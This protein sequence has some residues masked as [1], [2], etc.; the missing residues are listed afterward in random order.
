MIMLV[1]FCFNVRNYLNKILHNWWIEKK[2]T[3]ERLPGS[4]DL[5]PL[6]YYLWKYLKNIRYKTKTEKLNELRNLIIVITEQISYG[7]WRNTD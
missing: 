5:S 7:N 4:P 2:G 1:T 6:G 3:V